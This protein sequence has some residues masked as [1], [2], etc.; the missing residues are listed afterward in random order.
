MMSAESIKNNDPIQL[1]Q[2]IIFL[3]AELVKNEHKLHE[4]E[5]GY[6]NSVIEDLEQENAQL[7]KEKNELAEKLRSVRSIKYVSLTDTMKK[8]KIEQLPLNTQLNDVEQLITEHAEDK[9]KK[10][11]HLEQQ[12]TS[13]QQQLTKY[14]S[15]FTQM[16]N[17]LVE[18]IQNSTQQIHNEIESLRAVRKKDSQYEEKE[19]RLLKKI[20]EQK[21]F[22]Q[23]LNQEN[24]K[25]KAEKV[26]SVEAVQFNEN[27]SLVMELLFQVEE[28]LK[29][30]V[31]KSEVYEK[32]LDAKLA[33]VQALEI[34]LEQLTDEIKSIEEMD[35]NK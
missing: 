17:K 18:L 21:D 12:M 8:P 35:K 23:N 13:F 20:E 3:K 32:S 26:E 24:K 6:H 27:Y 11:L 5:S 9:D 30:V 2:M 10:Y 34:K 28:E 22:I 31:V 25:L 4:L 14:T 1:K 33:I 29:A 19:Q 7:S 15:T 16:E